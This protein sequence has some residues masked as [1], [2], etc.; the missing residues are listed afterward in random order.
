MQL[1]RARLFRL[2]ASSPVASETGN[3]GAIPQSARHDRRPQASTAAAILRHRTASP[4][5]PPGSFPARTAPPGR[6]ANTASLEKSSVNTLI[7]NT[8]PEFMQ[9][10]IERHLRRTFG[11]HGDLRPKAMS[12]RLPWARR[13]P[14]ARAPVACEHAGG[15]PAATATRKNTGQRIDWTL[16]SGIYATK[17]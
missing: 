17:N 14:F 10:K 11:E 1:I 15:R 8:F 4:G 12:A 16:L 6:P 9:P 5:S 3:R 7:T 2:R 13:Q